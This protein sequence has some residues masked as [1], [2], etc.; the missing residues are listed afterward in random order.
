MKGSRLAVAS[1]GAGAKVLVL[2]STRTVGGPGKGLLQLVPALAA[3]GR[4]QPVLCT[5]V[6]TSQPE[7]PFVRAAR[8]HGVELVLVRQRFNFDWQALRQLKRLVA[9]ANIDLI[10]TH[11]YKENFFGL[12]L[13]LMTGRRWIC[14]LH[15]TTDE[16]LKMKL[17]HALDRVLVRF[18]DRIV[19]VSRELAT[20]VVGHGA[21]PRV[22]IVENAIGGEVRPVN[23]FDLAAWR[24]RYSVQ[25]GRV[26][27]CVGRLSPEKGQDVLLEAAAILRDRDVRFQLLL[28]GDGPWRDSLARRT[29]ALGLATQAAFLGEQSRMELVYAAADML[30]LPSRKEGMPNVV[31]EAMQHGL[32]I[33]ATRVGAVPEMLRDGVEA[34]LVPPEQPKAL[35]QALAALLADPRRAVEIG[36]AGRR[37]LLPRFSPERRTEQMER[38][39]REVIESTRAEAT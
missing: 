21:E 3:R 4:V 31:L 35:A 39:Y 19:A 1:P 2:I 24:R 20:R 36:R 12:L 26:I 33:V 13:R 11:G 17:Y 6:R 22:R 37:A 23:A 29:V 10:Q 14:F 34:I 18:A 5:F 32:P 27:L 30:V 25:R 28:A 9:Q 7:T 15:G 38:V 16:N 8:E